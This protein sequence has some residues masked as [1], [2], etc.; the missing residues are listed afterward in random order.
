MGEWIK[1][2]K[3]TPR[4]PEVMRLA[5]LLG[6]S[7]DHAFGLCFRFWCWVD[8]NLTNCRLENATTEII[9]QIIGCENLG[10]Y[11]E[12]I[13]WIEVEND[14]IVV[15]NFE[16][17]LS[18]SAKRRAIS[19]KSA[20]DKRLTKCRLKKST[21]SRPDKNRLDNDKNKG[22]FDFLSEINEDIRD[23]VRDWMTYKSE[24]REGYKPMGLKQFLTLVNKRRAELGAAEV[25][26]RMRRAMAG[27]WKGWDFESAGKPT[28]VDPV[29]T[30]APPKGSSEK[31]KHEM[32]LAEAVK[33]ARSAG[34]SQSEIDAIIARMDADYERQKK[35][36]P[37]PVVA[38]S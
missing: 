30:N 38:Q 3:T 12:K 4:K 1:V 37:K 29:I 18:K 15:T 6:V 34:R 25:V 22:D 5:A 17:H 10:K 27:G 8:S 36:I 28:K 16:R 24:R 32:R 14:A 13:G 9:D 35:G 33:S 2:E 23:T 26:I 21:K 11:L 7:P 20:V 31:I 19:Q